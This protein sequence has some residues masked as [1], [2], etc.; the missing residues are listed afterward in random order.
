MKVSYRLL[1]FVGIIFLSACVNTSRNSFNPF[2]S[3]KNKVNKTNELPENTSSL[4]DKKQDDLEKEIVPMRTNGNGEISS[5]EI[6]TPEQLNDENIRS[7]HS[8]IAIDNTP[9]AE[10]DASNSTSSILEE[11]G[12]SENL[13]KQETLEKSPKSEKPDN[14]Y[15]IAA[16]PF[17]ILLGILL[18]CLFL[19]FL[20]VRAI[21]K[22]I[23]G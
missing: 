3:G 15:I 17:L 2:F 7:N 10:E 5:V 1:V 9:Q 19:I 20:I 22:A 23:T 4:T 21:V 12:V 11:N 16:W 14:D 18:V 13:E 8:D 6:E